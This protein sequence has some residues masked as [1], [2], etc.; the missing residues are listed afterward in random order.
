MYK[1]SI[2]KSIRSFNIIKTKYLLPQR[3]LGNQEKYNIRSQKLSSLKQDKNIII[4]FL[5]EN[6]NHVKYVHGV[7]LPEISIYMKNVA[8]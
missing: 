3:F 1:S 2:E 6:N 8:G 4:L 5:Q 7:N